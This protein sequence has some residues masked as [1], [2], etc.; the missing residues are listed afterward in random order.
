MIAV[1]AASLGSLSCKKLNLCSGSK[2]WCNLIHFLLLFLHPFFIDMKKKRHFLFLPRTCFTMEMMSLNRCSVFF[3]LLI[4]FT[5]SLTHLISISSDQSL[6]HAAAVSSTWLVANCKQI[7]F[8]YLA[9]KARFVERTANDCPVN[10][11]SHLSCGL[12][13]IYSLDAF[14][15]QMD[16][17]DWFWGA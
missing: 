11:F 12:A 17:L 7:S 9:I 13:S 14:S 5:C 4:L 2:F 8:C 1:L 3:P 10:T 6:S 15:K 16:T